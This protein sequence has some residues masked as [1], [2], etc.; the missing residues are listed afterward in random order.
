MLSLQTPCSGRV[1]RALQA[2]VRGGPE[3]ALPG[4]LCVPSGPMRQGPRYPNV[5]RS[6]WL[7]TPGFQG[8]PANRSVRPGLLVISNL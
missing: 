1:G 2:T 6:T 8:A 4:P 7:H 3:L 5:A